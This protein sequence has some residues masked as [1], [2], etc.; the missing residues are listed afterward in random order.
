MTD[1][2]ILQII[3]GA[4]ASGKSTYTHAIALN[5]ILAQIGSSIPGKSARLP[6]INHL[7]SRFSDEDVLEECFSSFMR[8]M[9]DIEYIFQNVTDSSFVVLDELCRST[10]YTDGF[11]LAWSICERIL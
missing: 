8:E 3:T 7:L 2:S 11:A 9:I 4:N 6:I 5:I 10:A 1:S